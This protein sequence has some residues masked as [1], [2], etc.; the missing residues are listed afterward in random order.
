MAM[1]TKLTP[2]RPQRTTSG[3]NPLAALRQEMDD[4]V[5]RFW[6]G[7]QEGWFGGPMVP[8]AD[9][10]ECDNAFEIRMDIPGFEA[11]NIDV[12]VHGNA[13]TLSGQ[14]KDE[15]EEKGKTYHCMERRSGSFSRTMT[16]PC[17]VNEDEVAAEYTQGVLTVKL[18]KCEEAQTKKIAVK[19]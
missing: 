6:D 16:L 4:L 15:K 13:V 11:K 12:Q 18:P 14:R 2:S 9:L 1:S 5:A 17:N 3:R 19:G 7:E 10:V 8:T